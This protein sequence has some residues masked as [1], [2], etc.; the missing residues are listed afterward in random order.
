LSPAAVSTSKWDA[1]D[2]ARVGGFVAALGEAALDLLDPQRGERILDVGCGEGTLTK[3]IF[4][5]GA[6]VLGID[7]SPE[8][9]AAARAKG[10]DALLL[11]AEDMQFYAEF[12]AA[13][14]N[15]TLHWVL[16]REQA[17]RAVFRALKS[18][19]RFA[20]ELGGEGNIARLREALDTEL[21][22]RGYVPPTES[23]NWY[24]SPEEFAFVYEA[25]GFDHIDARLIERPTPLGHGVG[26]WVT[27]FRKGW[28]DRAG[29]PE[30]ERPEIAAAVA[31]RFGS[32]IADYV[33]LRFIM[34]KPA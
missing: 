20:G 29:V 30:Q 26:E 15:A 4:E 6:T 18:G 10:V 2:Y 22:I 31:D 7:N 25:A 34:R 14:S 19:G 16:D 23:S 5:R 24:P 13:F 8:M 28:L 33:R 27:T 1:G 9:I 21:V 32:N 12:D 3:K 17:A 11:A